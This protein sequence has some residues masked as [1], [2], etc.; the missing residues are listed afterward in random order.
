M[1]GDGWVVRANVWAPA[2][3]SPADNW[4]RSRLYHDAHDHNFS[5][6]TVGY[7][8]PGYE[9]T[10]Y[11]YDPERTTGIAGEPVELRFLERTRLSQDKVMFY[12][13]SCDVHSQDYP[14]SLSISINLIAFDPTVMAQNQYAFDFDRGVVRGHSEN[15]AHGRVLVCQLAR[16]LGDTSAIPLLEQLAERHPS[17]RTRVESRIS[18]ASLAPSSAEETWLSALRDPHLHVRSVARRVLDAGTA[19]GRSVS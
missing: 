4:R 19:R 1:R 16:L 12:R 17:P 11:E 7:H 2:S 15:S 10:I 18:L 14:E 13:A 9:T 8:G 5:F 6:L 3:I